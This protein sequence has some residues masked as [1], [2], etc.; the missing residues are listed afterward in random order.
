MNNSTN[1]SYYYTMD[2]VLTLY[3]STWILDGL[4]LYLYTAFSVIGL[5]LS[6]FSLLIFCRNDPEFNIALYTYLRVYMFN[7]ILSSFINIFN[8]TYSSYR[9]LPWSNSYETS[10]YY[11]YILIPVANI[12]YYYSGVLDII[13][14]LDR[15]TYFNARIK[16]SFL[17]KLSPYKL[18]AAAF[19]FSFLM[20]FPYAFMYSP[21]SQTLNL[22]HGVLFT[23]WYSWPSAFA[24]SQFGT[25]LS[26]IVYAIRDFLVMFIQ[27]GLNVASVAMFKIYLNKKMKVRGL[28]Q[29][30]TPNQ[31]NMSVTGNL[32]GTRNI[33]VT[34][35]T[36]T[37]NRQA[38]NRR[39]GKCSV[40]AAA[41]SSHISKSDQRATLMAICMCLFSILEH[42][43]M[44]LS[45]IY[46]YFALDIN[47]FVFYLIGDGLQP[48]KC[49]F[50][51]FLFLAFNKVFSKAV[52]Q[53]L[54]L[55]VQQN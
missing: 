54:R 46:P 34:R 40:A 32:S 51:F 1:A 42:L 13:I 5:L 24:S 28:N 12:C 7:N 31:A 26:F 39:V 49:C 43:F 18:S 37:N 19:I 55:G 4:N 30:H 44:A 52:R 27:I 14:I 10:V 41:S 45:I 17:F 9:F 50:D 48:V 3:G 23:I 47:V 25:I 38:D 35:E 15:M 33:S 53:Y 29:T 36:V 16:R 6:I 11:N 8:F 21:T 2:Q 22:G 20:D